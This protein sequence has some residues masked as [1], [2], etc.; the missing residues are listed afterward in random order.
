MPTIDWVDGP[1]LIVARA[2]HQGFDVTAPTS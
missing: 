2:Y 1:P